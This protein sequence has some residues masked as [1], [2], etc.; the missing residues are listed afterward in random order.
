MCIV[1]VFISIKK[2][3][4]Q[5]SWKWVLR[6]QEREQE[7]TTSLYVSVIESCGFLLLQK[8]KYRFLG[9]TLQGTC[10]VWSGVRSQDL[11]SLLR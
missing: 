4:S 2:K 1:C 9:S 6:V 7:F 11:E 8:I 5:N 3:K 10:S